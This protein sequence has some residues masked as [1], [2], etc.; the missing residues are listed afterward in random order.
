[1][2]RRVK[3]SLLFFAAVFFLATSIYSKGTSNTTVIPSIALSKGKADRVIK[4]DRPD[5]Q[6]PIYVGGVILPTK[7]QVERTPDLKVNFSRALPDTFNNAVLKYFRKPV[8]DQGQNMSCAQSSGI[9][10]HLTYVLNIA[11]N[12]DGSQQANMY[13]Q[14][15]T[16]A[17]LNDGGQNGS[18]FLDGWDIVNECGIPDLVTWGVSDINAAQAYTWMSGY[19]KYESSMRNRYVEYTKVDIS[20]SAGI[21]TLKQWIYDFGDGSA[22]GGCATFSVNCIRPLQDRLM[23]KV[24]AGY[25]KT[26]WPVIPAWGATGGHVMLIVGWDDSVRVDVN[27]DGNYTN[28]LDIDGNGVAGNV[29]DWEIGGWLVANSWGTAWP[30]APNQLSKGFFYMLYRTG[31]LAPGSAYKDTTS[32][33]STTTPTKVD[34]LK[35]GGLSTGKYAYTLRAKNINPKNLLTYR[36]Q[37][38]YNK[39]NNLS[40]LAGVA[41][42]TNATNPEYVKRFNVFNYQGGPKT[43]LGTT[44]TSATTID[45]ALDAKPLLSYVNNKAIK[46]FFQVESQN[47]ASAAGTVN[48]FALYDTRGASPVTKTCTQTNVTIPQSTTTTLSIVYASEAA[49]LNITT[50]ALPNATQNQSYTQQL[51]GEGGTTPYTWKLCENV[52]SEEANT[53]TFPAITTAL[54]LAPSDTDDAIITKSLGFEFPFYGQ[55]YS[56]IHISTD[57]N[58]MLDSQFVY[59]RTPKNLVAAKSIAVLGADLV[60][61]TGDKIYFSGDA[62]KA[63][64]RWTTKHLWGASGMIAANIDVAAEIYPSGKINFFYGSGMSG[65]NSSMVIGTS[66]GEGTYITFNYAKITDIPDNHKFTLVPQEKVNGMAVSSSGVF[67]GTPTNNIGNYLVTFALEDA[68]QIIKRKTF[69]LK[70]ES[71]GITSPIADYLSKPLQV[72][73]RSGSVVFSF[74]LNRKSDVAIEAFA[75]NGRKIQTLFKAASVSGAQKVIW[76]TN[77]KNSNVPNGIYLCRISIGNS[78]MVKRIALF[79]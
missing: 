41:N 37:I 67:S 2:S 1:M 58:I 51:A 43:M 4:I 71:T 78:N 27:G 20:T 46:Y 17:M 48:S 7:E 59:V 50:T 72:Y 36:V 26:G 45:I 60:Y 49:P 40:L 29:G 74:E 35:N 22:N 44:S 77:N 70:I 53:G 65:E 12:L 68:T 52:Y 66:G 39:R 79:R 47:V 28:N 42:D 76:N 56:K 61:T 73:N 21:N 31:N 24:P 34:T 33:S 38:N 30:S 15:F 9:S 62:T 64:V 3:L 11:R 54:T 63:T 19:D 6:S 25:S 75:L 32:S 55:K 18:S 10:N 69:S 5:G 16:Y 8:A 13:P 23:Y 57:G 14:F